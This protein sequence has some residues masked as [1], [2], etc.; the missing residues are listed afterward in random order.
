MS[1]INLEY[2]SIEDNSQGYVRCLL[3]VYPTLVFNVAD[4][5]SFS[6][7]LNQNVKSTFL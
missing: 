6:S 3:C 4:T 2:L 1:H 7:Y 5:T